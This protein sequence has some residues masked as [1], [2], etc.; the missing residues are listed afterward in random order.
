MRELI[1][2][3]SKDTAPSLGAVVSVY[4]RTFTRLMPFFNGYTQYCYGYEKSLALLT[5]ARAERRE[6]DAFLAK[7]EAKESNKHNSLQSLLIKPVQRICKYPLLFRE[8]LKHLERS[9]GQTESLPHVIECRQAMA[10]VEEIAGSVNKQLTEAASRDAVFKAWSELGGASGGI[11]ADIVTPHR[12]LVKTFN[13]MMRPAPFAS[14]RL[15]PYRVYVFSDLVVFATAA[16]GTLTDKELK[17]TPTKRMPLGECPSALRRSALQRSPPACNVRPLPRR[18]LNRTD[19]HTPTASTLASRSAPRASR[20]ASTAG[21]CSVHISKGSMVKQAAE[22]AQGLRFKWI[23]RS[24]SSESG[25]QNNNLCSH[26]DAHLREPPWPACRTSALRL[27]RGNALIAERCAHRSATATHR[28]G[29][30]G[31]NH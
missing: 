18:R 30:S 1:A 27:P 10:A 25:K 13:A 29:A 7:R 5:S 6:L 19:P 9:P 11:C 22:G 21:E 26:C 3:Q 20:V 15:Q 16:A 31:D 28:H 4:A 12:R 8:I 24:T 17:V 23:S 14:N 2:Q